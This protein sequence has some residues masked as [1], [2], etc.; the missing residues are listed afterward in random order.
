MLKQKQKKRIEEFLARYGMDA[1]K[2]NLDEN[3]DKFIREMDNGLQGTGS[4][5]MIP[6]YI[7][8]DKELPTMEPV[9]TIDAGG[10]NFRVAVI[11]FD[12]D[13]NPVIEDFKL[14]PMPGS[15][16]EVS[17]EEFFETMADYIQPV[18]HRSNKISFCFSYPAEAMPNKDGKIIKFSKE[19]NI[20]DVEGE[21][22][23]SNLKQVFKKRGF[24]EDKEIIV[25]NDTVATLLAGRAASPARAFDGYVGFILGTGTNICYSEKCSNITK[26]PQLSEQE[27]TMLINMESGA[28]DKIPRGQIDLEFDAGT[29]NPGDF[30]FEKTISGAYQG[31]LT[32]A[33]IRKAAEDGIF[34]DGFITELKNIN[35][36]AAKQI[37]DFLFYP[38]GDNPLAKCCAKSS[39]DEDRISLFYIIDNI[40]ERIAKFVT[41]S[42]TAVLEKAGSG[43]NPC[44]PACITADGST[45][46]KS[47]LFRSKLEY[48]IKS[49][50]NDVKGIYCEFVKVDNGTLIGTSIAGLLN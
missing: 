7:G 16:G 40:F 44:K 41:F 1:G 5:L 29:L 31:G 9:I 47:K 2:I 6:T 21:L 28:Y 26:V 50:T 37:D 32:L 49:Y 10:T 38:Y 18:L 35:E 46:Y 39:D 22:V 48:Y 19:I 15:K 13:R 12:E 11:H 45:F 23:G 43:M 27:G 8:M 33:T 17:K 36:L 14:Y 25:L 4:L 20:S 34:S 3:R 24:N 30:A 42:L